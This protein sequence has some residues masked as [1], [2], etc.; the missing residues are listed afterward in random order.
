VSA[1]A[2]VL[3]I[4][5]AV[6]AAV[7]FTDVSASAGVGGDTYDSTTRHSLGINWIDF[8]DDD[9][10]DL[11]LVNGRNLLAH[12]YEN[13]GDGTFTNRD[14]WLPVL[15]NMDMS[16]SL[17]ADY[18]NDGDQDLYIWTDHTFLSFVVP[19]P[20]DGPP[21]VLLKNLWAE[22]GGMPSVP[23]FQDVAAAAGVQDLAV[24]PLGAQPGMRAKAGAWLDHD[25]DGDQ[26]LYIGHM[27][28][29]AGGNVANANRFYR[30]EGNGTFTDATV[31]TGLDLLNDPT[32]Y[33]PTLAVIG[34]HLDQDLWADIYVANV[35]DPAP[36]FHDQIFRNNGDGTFTDVT[37]AMPGV[38]DD[39]EA[40]MGIDVADIDLDG[41]WDL[42]ISD[43]YNTTLDALPLGNVLYLNNGDGTFADNSAPAAGV[44]SD[45][46]WG[47]SFFDADQDGWE[48]LLVVTM[49]P[50][51]NGPYFYRNEGGGVFS[52]L[53]A[54]DGMA[55]GDA[56]GSATADFDRDGDLDV[57]IVNSLG[58]P[59]QLFRNDTSPA[60]SWLE[61]KLRGVASSRDA[62]GAVVEAEADG[63]LR[64]RQI[65]G[66]SSAHSQDDLVVHF[67]LG[68]ATTVDV[69][70]VRWPSGIVDSLTAVPANQFLT[71]VEGA[72]SVAVG[73]STPVSGSSPAAYALYG[74]L[75]NP[76]RHATQITF[77]LPVAAGVRL[78]I[79]DVA[80]R[81]V[82]TLVDRELGPGRHRPEWD[83]R[84]DLG[85][86][87]ARGV[88]F[89]RL[90]TGSFAAVRAAVRLD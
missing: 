90:E 64:L 15:P 22:N 81:R 9:W 25:R 38:G 34:A 55:C 21:N 54:V 62:I 82:R 36:Y 47:V 19:N 10:P 63:V 59:L 56:R 35:A 23:L 28:I 27:V 52:D 32:K 7:Q 51:T 37:A 14:A 6:P 48:D 46:S 40:D 67:G 4:P 65:K 89:V 39:S 42:Y 80:G 87:A 17:F 71:V 53:S 16:Q 75:P 43:L 26:D 60:G 58:G 84:D 2:I 68:A 70:R 30:N 3:A 74:G 69:L 44:A 49:T 66:G 1:L 73:A 72:T 11:F 20:L 29:G 77:D 13:D 50:I 86:R 83:G 88:Y 61:I 18:D 78:A 31:A 41:D 45:N 24:P 33:R 57:A 79:F 76:F 8:N 5:G 85:R 12:L